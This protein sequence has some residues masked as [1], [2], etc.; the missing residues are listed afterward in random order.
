MGSCGS[1][2]GGGGSGGG[3][4]RGGDGGQR[5]QLL[6]GMV[7]ADSASG[8]MHARCTVG[9]PKVWVMEQPL[10]ALS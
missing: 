7:P 2:G 5:C 10:D 8:G 1:W 4:G 9:P 6:P 3:G